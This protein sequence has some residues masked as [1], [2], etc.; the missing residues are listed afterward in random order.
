MRIVPEDVGVEALAIP[1]RDLEPGG[2]ADDMTVGQHQP[3]RREQE[4]GA[5]A[6]RVAAS[7]VDLHHCGAD[8]LRGRYDGARIGVQ[9]RGVC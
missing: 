1:H 6:G 8:A 2:T 5:A 4:S 3:V 7:H 9:E